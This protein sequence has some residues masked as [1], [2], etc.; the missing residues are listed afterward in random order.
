MTRERKMLRPVSIPSNHHKL[1]HINPHSPRSKEPESHTSDR[2]HNLVLSLLRSG[3][4]SE[5]L[6]ASELWLWGSLDW[7][8]GTT[9][10]GGTGDSLGAEVGSVTR[11]GGGVD[12]TG[13][14]PDK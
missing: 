14:G 11:L 3:S 2:R 12:D 10:S 4:G 9:E 8:L 6:L 1:F 7:A 5:S 13:V